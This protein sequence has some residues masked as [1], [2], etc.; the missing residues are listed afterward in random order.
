MDP[1]FEREGL[2]YEGLN[3]VK[4]WGRLRTYGGK[5]VEN[6]VQ[7][8]ARDC[9]RES[10]SN[11]YLHNYA[12]VMHIHDEIVIEGD[13]A[14]LHKIEELMGR[15]IAWAPGLPLRGDGYSTKYYRKDD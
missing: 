11:V 8:T 13:E 2:T 14:D 1:K 5:L 10:L 6:I 4:K 12:T 3:D 7:A 15:E 9:L